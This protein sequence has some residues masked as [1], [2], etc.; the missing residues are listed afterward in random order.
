MIARKNIV[1][2]VGAGASHDFEPEMGTGSELFEN[3]LKRVNEKKELAYL[4]NMLDGIEERFGISINSQDRIRFS[5]ELKKY[6]VAQERKGSS[7]SIDDFPNNNKNNDKFWTIGTFTIAFHILGY[8]DACLRKA[9]FNKDSWLCELNDFIFKYRL[10]TWN[11]P[12][13][14]LKIVTFNYDRLIEEFLYRKHGQ[15]ITDFLKNS[16]VHI[17]SKVSPLP[18]QRNETKSNEGFLMF[19]HPNDDAKR[20]LDNKDNIVLMYEQRAEK[21]PYLEEAK[22][23]IS[24]ARVI[25]FLGYGYDEYNNNNLGLTELEDKTFIANYYDKRKGKFE[26]FKKKDVWNKIG[27]KN[28]IIFRNMN[29]TDF[30][31]DWLSKAVAS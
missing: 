22:R 13:V 12:L 3:I 1:L 4:S 8:E 24:N 15:A 7:G 6:K 20:I 11:D 23:F 10:H 27:K 14:D 18:W 30:I 2:V 29:C 25:L 17:Y 21:N 26:K 16:L 31:R 5:D 9:S 28:R 19:G